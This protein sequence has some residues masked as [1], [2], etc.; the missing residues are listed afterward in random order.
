[1]TNQDALN[2]KMMEAVIRGRL[3]CV[4]A[5]GIMNKL[6]ME[7]MIEEQDLLRNTPPGHFQEVIQEITL[8]DFLNHKTLNEVGNPKIKGV[9]SI[10][11]SVPIKKTLGPMILEGFD[12]EAF[13]ALKTEAIAAH[14][15]PYSK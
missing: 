11:K 3:C 4:L 15:K 1:M 5:S 8:D 10:A 14:S 13:E 2:K 6:I 12:E 9:V 7:K